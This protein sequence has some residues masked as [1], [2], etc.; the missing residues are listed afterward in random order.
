LN[1]APFAT[2]N[3]IWVASPLSVLTETARR[4]EPVRREHGRA[5]S[6]RRGGACPRRRHAHVWS[7][8]QLFLGESLDRDRVAAVYEDGV[9]TI[10]TPVAEQAKPRKVEITYAGGGGQA[11]AAAPAAA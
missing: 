11:V 7:C 8:R 2:E 3:V 6:H 4:C 10:T 9:L 1:T 5:D